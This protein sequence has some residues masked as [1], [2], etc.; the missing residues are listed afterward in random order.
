MQTDVSYMSIDQEAKR[1][2]FFRSN[3]CLALRGGSLGTS[4]VRMRQATTD[5]FSMCRVVIKVGL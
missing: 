1:V 4:G 5:C 2:P 3:T